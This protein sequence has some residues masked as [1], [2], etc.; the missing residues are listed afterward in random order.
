MKKIVVRLLIGLAVLILLAALATHLFLDGA[1]KRGVETI[2]PELTKVDVKLDAV[3]LS[4]LSGAGKIKG[5]VV[6][7]PEGFKMPSA[8]SV[9]TASLALKPGSLLSHKVV[10]QS[11]NVQA[12]EVTFETDLRGNNLSRILA[13]LEA[14]TGGDEKQPAKPKEKE[15]KPG[16]KLQ[17]DD[18][19]VSGGKI[20]LSVTTP[21]GPKSATVPLPE[22]HFQA[23]GTGPEGITATELAKKVLKEVLE[24]ASEAAAKEATKLASD[25][26]KSATAATKS[27][28][29]NA[30][31]KVT[32]GIGD[33]FKK[34]Q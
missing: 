12:P 30:V 9:G 14:A 5:L 18:F 10:V 34:K 23:L 31:E 26:G 4:V 29:T 3:S 32:K 13:N 25:L 15:A 21:L 16:K 27:L 33:L 24:K 6:G 11:I 28:S 22:I 8:I 7:N 19:L 20:N 17:V 1:I 2:G